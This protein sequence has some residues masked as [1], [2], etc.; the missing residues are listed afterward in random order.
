MLNKPREA[1]IRNVN[2]HDSKIL[3]RQNFLIQRLAVPRESTRTL[4]Q[5]ITGRYHVSRILNFIIVIM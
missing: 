2:G 3:C 1:K 5:V 4:P